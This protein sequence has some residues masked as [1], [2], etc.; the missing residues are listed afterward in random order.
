MFLCTI[1]RCL[2]PRQLV[3]GLQMQIWSRS[4]SN[5]SRAA[6]VAG[7]RLVVA[8]V[9]QRMPRKNREAS[10]FHGRCVPF[11]GVRRRD[12]SF[13][14][15]KQAFRARS[16]SNDT[17]APGLPRARVCGCRGRRDRL[18]HGTRSHRARCLHR[19]AGTAALVP[20]ASF[21]VPFDGV[22]RQSRAFQPPGVH[23]RPD[24]RRMVRG[25]RA[26]SPHVSNPPTIPSTARQILLG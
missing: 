16:P 2:T 15:G 8:G 25:A 14:V 13:L 20:R 11:D 6:V 7:T 5:S 26:G 1:R 21:R 9:S 10:A 24:F 12:C 19:D 23:S 22:R 4:P 17:R 3:V 18:A